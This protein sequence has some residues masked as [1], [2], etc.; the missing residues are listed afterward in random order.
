MK[1]SRHWVRI[2]A[3]LVAFAL[4]GTPLRAAAD[5]IQGGQVNVSGA[6][7]FQDFF[8]APASTNDFID[9]DGDG[10]HGYDP[11]TPPFV[12]Q[13]APAYACGGGWIGWWLVQY[14]GVGS[15]NGLNEFV[16]YQLLGTIPSAPPSGDLMKNGAL[17]TLAWL[18]IESTR[19]NPRFP[20]HARCT[21]NGSL[22]SSQSSHL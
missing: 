6:T 11:F 12:D 19:S 14:R 16:D 10:L 2:G 17:A 8:T 18:R 21:G 5:T 1:S 22:V 4:A 9:A 20:L 15:G 13:L 7:L 3:A